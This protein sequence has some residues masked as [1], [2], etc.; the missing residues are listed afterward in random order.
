MRQGITGIAYGP[1]VVRPR[2]P[3]VAEL[4]TMLGV[5]PSLVYDFNELASPVKNKVNP[6][7]Y[8]LSPDGVLP[9]G[10]RMANTPHH[11]ILGVTG[12]NDGWASSTNL[13]LAP[14]PSSF[15]LMSLFNVNTN[16]V[17]Q[18]NQCS[19]GLI[20]TGG[21]YIMIRATALGALQFLC[22]DGTNTKIV[23]AGYTLQAN[24]KRPIGVVGGYDAGAAVFYCYATRT[25]LGVGTLAKGTW[26]GCVA[27]MGGRSTNYAPSSNSQNYT[28]GFGAYAF[29]SALNNKYTQAPQ[30]LRQL[31][32]V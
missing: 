14:G 7:T 12:T 4:A 13:A 16:P 18:D 21:V 10:G 29:G 6:G 27:I 3:S 11:G 23:T 5:T 20:D 31:K 17:A 26:L 24:D 1:T 19:F 22:R 8:D 9:M 28:V 15:C 2:K 25:P 30:W 32:W